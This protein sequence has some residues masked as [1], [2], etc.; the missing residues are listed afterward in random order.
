MSNISNISKISKISCNICQ[1]DECALRSEY[2][3]IE[4][5]WINNDSVSDIYH[6]IVNFVKMVTELNDTNDIV[7]ELDDLS[8]RIE[9]DSTNDIVDDFIY[10]KRYD[11][12]RQK[13]EIKYNL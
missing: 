11:K 13:Y 9:N 1:K 4:Y 7:D 6:M 8:R 3:K 10:G 5:A 12:I 2:R